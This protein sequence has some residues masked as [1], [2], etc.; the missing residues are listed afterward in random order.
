MQ[1]RR[2]LVNQPNVQKIT[3]ERQTDAL[4]V[5]AVTRSGTV[6]NHDKGKSVETGVPGVRRA[7]Q[8]PPPFDH[9]Q[10]RETFLKARREFTNPTTSSS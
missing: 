8:K 4:L 1:E 5:R 9:M 3:V 7:G 10:E 6:M 2:P